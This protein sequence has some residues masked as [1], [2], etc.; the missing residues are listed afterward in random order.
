MMKTVTKIILIFCLVSISFSQEIVVTPYGVSPREALV[1]TLDMFDVAYNALPNV[2]IG[3][4]LYLKAEFVDSTTTGFTWAVTTSPVNSTYTLGTEEAEGD[5]VEF[6]TFTPDS[7]GTYVITV[8]EGATSGTIT[9]YAGTFLGIGTAGTSDTGCAGFCHSAYVDDWKLTGHSDMLNRAFDGTLSSHYGSYC[10][11]CHVVGQDG[12]DNDGFDDFDF[13]YPDSTALVDTYNSTDGH[14][15]DGLYDDLAAAFPEAFRRANIQCESCHGPGSEH[16]GGPAMA[17]S[18]DAQTCAW[19]HDSGTHHAFPDQ[20]RVSQHAALDYGAYAGGRASCAPCHSGSGFIA[21]VDGGM[22]PLTEAP[23]VVP[24]TCATCHDPHSVDNEHQLRGFDEVVLGDGTVI[25]DGGNG[26]LCMNCHKGR[27]DPSY[28][29]Y[30]HY[31]SHFGPHHGPQAD[32]LAGANVPTFGQTL[33]SSAHL[34]GTEACVSCHMAGDL[35]DDAGNIT[36][37]GGHSFSM[38]DTD[39]GVD[40]VE[41]CAS[42]HGDIGESFAEKMYYFNG[43]ADHDGDGVD[44]GLQEEVHGLLEEVALLLPPLDTTEVDIGGDYVYTLTEVKAAFN[45]LFVEEDRSLGVHN[46]AFTVALLKVTLN[47]LMDGNMAGELVAIEDVPNDQGYQVR[48]VWDNL[49]DDLTAYDPVET[50]IV[51]RFDDY[52]DEE[53]W[54]NVGEVTAD[55]SARYALDVATI[56]NNVGTDTAWTEFKIVAITQSGVVVESEVGDGFS[57]DNLVPAAPTGV[58]ASAIDN[59]S[60][61]LAWDASAAPDVNYYKI[62][63]DGVEIAMTA[64]LNYTDTSLDLGDYTYTIAAVDFSGNEGD[65]SPGVDATVLSVEDGSMPLEYS[66]AQNYPNPFNPVTTIKFSLI[67]AGMVNLTVINSAGQVVTEL[68]NKKMDAGKHSINFVAENLPTGL[69]FYT[70]S[71]KNFNQTKKMVLLK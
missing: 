40:H 57:I 11:G 54:T 29:E 66:L 16:N 15:Y 60:V 34:A 42:C 43:E 48:V 23:P 55:G 38:V 70:I 12:A 61:E 63:R 24:I 41:A 21:W 27:R 71:S 3:T 65:V 51:K 2:G 59:Y 9:I 35:T 19:C 44:E 13:V 39:T 62:Y 10:V 22:E 68:V 20:W 58:M 67:E 26:K 18:L 30:V 49:V 14:F 17:S 31:S 32:M 33:P 64:D 5:N 53:G 4:L 37:V 52:G 50:Y 1:D 28:Y 8:T 45:Y 46:P 69:Y 6:N 47:A 7:T 25:T 36:H 56:F